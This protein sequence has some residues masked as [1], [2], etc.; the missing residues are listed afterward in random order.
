M[1]GT[2]SS[3]VSLIDEHL[4]NAIVR[5]THRTLL[6]TFS[7]GM[8]L[9][10]IFGSHRKGDKRTDDPRIIE[11]CFQGIS[12]NV[13]R[14]PAAPQLSL[15][16]SSVDQSIAIAIARRVC[17]E[18]LEVWYSEDRGN[19]VDQYHH[20]SAPQ[21]EGPWTPLVS[22]RTDLK[23]HPLTVEAMETISSLPYRIDREVRKNLMDA[24]ELIPLG[25]TENTR[26]SKR[27][28]F[29]P[30]RL[31]EM[32]DISDVFYVAVSIACTAMRMYPKS[33]G[34][35]HGSTDRA[36]RAMI[37]AAE[38]APVDEI[39][40][41]LF[42]QNCRRH[43][44]KEGESLKDWCKRC[45]KDPVKA[46]AS[47]ACGRD[48]YSACREY[49]RLE[50]IPTKD[51]VSTLF[52][53]WDT[54]G[55]GPK[56]IH[57]EKS[58]MLGKLPDISLIDVTHKDYVHERK[59][60]MAT[61]AMLQIPRFCL[62]SPEAQEKQLKGFFNPKTYGSGAGPVCKSLRGGQEIL[63]DLSL[64]LPEL[65]A[66]FGD[67]HAKQVDTHLHKMGGQ[68]SKA[69]DDTFEDIVKM[70]RNSKA[71]F[72]VSRWEDRSLGNG[73]SMSPFRFEELE[74]DNEDVLGDDPTFSRKGD[75]IRA[76]YYCPVRGKNKGISSTIDSF[77]IDTH[78]TSRFSRL[79]HRRDSTQRAL[80]VLN[81]RDMGGQG[82]AIHD[83]MAV[84]M[85]DQAKALEADEAAWLQL[86]PDLTEAGWVSGK[87]RMV[88]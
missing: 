86:Y 5:E 66:Q 3:G 37:R 60:L 41:E 26:F 46:L 68:L 64:M 16:G 27:E 49:A 44:L 70:N 80:Q 7:G 23:V 19:T 28:S 72:R 53:E 79:I 11:S 62:M 35:L 15:P 40:W 84:R 83:A 14:S 87:S 55:S 50:R 33:L 43:W 48:E 29:M 59:R 32:S 36:S 4:E 82:Y 52:V 71:E 54:E 76:E 58:K 8:S 88:S 39:N 38:P 30:Y 9:L 57:L 81:L 47:G 61:I 21:L 78:G 18:I 22:K 25:E 10:E 74:D 6:E 17:E 2:K 51:R 65:R 45:L 20:T 34:T 12:M 13:L 69:F 63:E 42:L 75:P 31:K 56:V 73:S 67:L 77:V 1:S 24:R 85:G